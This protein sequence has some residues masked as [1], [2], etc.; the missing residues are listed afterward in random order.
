MNS[1]R[2]LLAWQA[3]RELIKEVYQATRAFPPE[4]RFGLTLQLRRAAVSAAAN[5]A[6]GYARTGLRETGHGLSISLGSLAEVDTLPA[7]AE[8]Q[9][10]IAREQLDNLEALRVRSGQ[11]C[12]GLLRSLRAK[13]KK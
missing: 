1:H 2:K 5:I 7:V 3:C 8:D 12:S 10:Y 13:M 11:L 6:E 9:E 4:E